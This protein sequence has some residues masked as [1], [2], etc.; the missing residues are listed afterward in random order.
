L[1]QSPVPARGPVDR[2]NDNGNAHTAI[3]LRNSWIQR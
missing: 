1:K 2:E 3:A